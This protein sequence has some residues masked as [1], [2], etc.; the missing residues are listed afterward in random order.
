MTDMLDIQ[1]GD[2]RIARLTL[3]QP[4]RRNAVTAAMWAALPGTL[5][6]LERAG[7]KVLIVQGEGAHFSAGADISEFG[8]LYATPESSARISADILAALDALAAFPVPTVA[9][10]R[11]ACVGGGLGLALACD[12]RFADNTARFA[13]TPARLGLVYP[14]SDLARLVE[15]IGAPHAKDMLFSARTIK[16]KRAEKTGLVNKVVK[17]DE[18][19]TEVAT[20]AAGLA[21]QSTQSARAMKRLFAAYAAGQRQQSDETRTLFRNG[22]SSTDFREGYTAFMEKRPPAF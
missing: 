8:T 4:A 11:G 9:S 17:P 10:I 6:D 13:I 16:A 20:Y 14:F 7:P 21:A 3:S 18:L 5:D 22:F 2:D 19:E 12:I 1:I 15:A